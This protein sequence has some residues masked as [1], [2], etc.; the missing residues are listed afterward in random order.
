MLELFLSAAWFLLPAMVANMAPVFAKKYKWSLDLDKPL[1][2][3]IKL[4][5][6][7]L[8]GENKTFRGLVYGVIFAFAIGIIQFTLAS[9]LSAF[10]NLELL[11]NM[12][13]STYLGLSILLGFGAIIGDAL[14]SFIKRQIEIP[15]GDSWFP[16]DQTDFIFGAAFFALP[17]GILNPFEYLAMLAVGFTLHLLST[18]FGYKYGFKDKPI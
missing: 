14:E 10:K 12:H 9:T 3:G 2:R 13:L 18:I 7:R 4:R 15:P 17:F 6:K 8:F 5:G 11:E 1:D 16:F